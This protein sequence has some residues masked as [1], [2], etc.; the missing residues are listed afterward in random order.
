[1]AHL[2]NPS[3]SGSR[4]QEAFGSKPAWADTSRNPHHKN[5]LMEELKVKA[6]SSNPSTTTKK[7]KKA[8]FGGG[9]IKTP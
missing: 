6:L 9:D 5:L 3:Y 4:D 2:S 1:V 7:R 8:L